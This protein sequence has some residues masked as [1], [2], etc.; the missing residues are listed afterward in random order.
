MVV[1]ADYPFLDVMFTMFI[2][3]AGVIW[4]AVVV[5]VL[6]DNFRRADH[7]GWAKA[8]WMLF[9]IFVPIIGVIAYLVS[10]ADRPQ[11]LPV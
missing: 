8:G 9:I 5:M 3:F 7:S 2:F 11:A 6:I 4:I 10:S 1:A